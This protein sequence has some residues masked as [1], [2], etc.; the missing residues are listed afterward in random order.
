M[1]ASSLSLSLSCTHTH[2]GCQLLLDGIPAEVLIVPLSLGDRDKHDP[3]KQQTADFISVRSHDISS[4]NETLPGEA[5]RGRVITHC[6]GSF[7]NPDLLTP[8]L[9]S[10][11]QNRHRAALG[12]ETGY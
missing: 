4:D 12:Q 6:E 9:A 1:H 5:R 3:H 10:S 7:G 8:A 2:T 11:T